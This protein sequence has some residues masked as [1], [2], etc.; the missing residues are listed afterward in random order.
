SPIYASKGIATVDFPVYAPIITND[1]DIFGGY[2]VLLHD[3]V[4]VYL[5][6]VLDLLLDIPQVTFNNIEGVFQLLEKDGYRYMQEEI[7]IDLDATISDITLMS[8]SNFVPQA[9]LSLEVGIILQEIGWL[10]YSS[11]GVIA[12]AR[13]QINLDASVEL[14]GTS[15]GTIGV[16]FDFKLRNPDYNPPDPISSGLIPGFTWLVAIPALIGAAAVGLIIRRR[17]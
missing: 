15:Y 7:N 2:M 4:D 1:W 11:T 14:E 9:T 8:R 5:D 17:K 13:T 6:Q 3:I 10:A 12:G 16:N